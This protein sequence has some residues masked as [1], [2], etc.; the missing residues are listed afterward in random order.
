MKTS[1]KIFSVVT[2]ASAFLL[3]F[4]LNARAESKFKPVDKSELQMKDNPGAPGA[5]AMI[6]EWGDDQ[7]DNQGTE[8]EYYRLKIFTEEGKKYADIEIPFLK[9]FFNIRDIKARTTHPDG[10][11]SDFSG[12]V[13]EKVVVKSHGVKYLAKTF[14]FPDVRPGDVLEYR[15]TRSWDNRMLYSSQWILQKDLFIRKAVLRMKPYLGEYYSTYL[16]LG[17]PKDKFPKSKGDIYVLE[18]ENIPAYEEENFSPPPTQ[19]KP[20]VDFY[21]S[22]NKLPDQDKFWSDYFKNESKLV[23]KFIGDRGAIREAVQSI[24]MPSDPYQTKLRKIYARVHQIRN[25]SYE[26][27]KTEQ[28]EKREKLKDNDNVEDVWSHGYGYS[29]EL[30][31]LFVALVRAA[32]IGAEVVRVSQRDDTFFIKGLL[33]ARQM[34]GEVTL[35]HAD[36]IDYFLNPGN[37]YCPFGLLSWE[38][39]GVAGIRLHANGSGEFVQTPAALYTDADTQR[40]ALLRMEDGALKGT[41][42]VTYTGQEALARRMSARDEDESEERKDLEDSLKNRLPEGASVKLDKIM[43][44]DDPEKPLI[45]Q[46][47]IEVPGFGSNVGSRLI[48]PAAIFQSQSINPFRHE[49]RVNPVYFDYPFQESDEISLELPSG[50]KIEKLPDPKFENQIFAFYQSQWRTEGNKVLFTRK[51]FI[52]GIMFPLEY[53]G[54]LRSFYESVN[55]DDQQAAVLRRAQVEGGQ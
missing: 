28:E 31:R 21:Y 33:D 38:N 41:V 2:L 22:N 49:K 48:V 12:K 40:K 54:A 19:M 46:Y 7:D 3:L 15:F 4:P 26:R 11:V 23:E 36:G 50:Y 18:L 39:T 51:R 55:T 34:N 8:Q 53:Y 52:N 17:V 25:L 27:S 16:T 13:F 14:T 30:N 20:R 29:N 1:N 9:D 24:V 47:D 44:L 43:G 32:G 35:A 10:S 5:H 45:V 42:Y 6:L 37:P